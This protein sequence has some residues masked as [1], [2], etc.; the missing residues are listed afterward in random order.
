MLP[1]KVLHSD[2][3]HALA[4]LN[5]RNAQGPDRVPSIVLQNY[6]SVLASCLVILIQLCILPFPFNL[7]GSVTFCLFLKK[8]VT[9]LIPQT[10]FIASFFFF[11]NM[12]LTT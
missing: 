10:S 1:I 8:K 4:A 7:A 9:I 12:F 2:A 5:P 3:F 11:F 6:T